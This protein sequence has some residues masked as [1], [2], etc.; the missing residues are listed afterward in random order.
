MRITVLAAIKRA[1]SGHMDSPRTEGQ[2]DA[3]ILLRANL[4]QKGEREG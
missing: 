1:G 2:V 4:I 3:Q